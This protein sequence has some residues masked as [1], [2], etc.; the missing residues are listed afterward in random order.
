MP[1]VGEDMMQRE[2]SHELVAAWIGMATLENNL[3]SCSEV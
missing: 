2:L 1:S 3:I